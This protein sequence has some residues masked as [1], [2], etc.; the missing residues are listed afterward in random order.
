MPRCCPPCPLE[1]TPSGLTRHRRTCKINRRYL[2][3]GRRVYAE[4]R[5]RQ[6]DL[7]RIQLETDITISL[8][9]SNFY[10]DR[11]YTS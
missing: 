9:F 7:D 10:A 8:S 4:R 5:L 1:S 2:D 6:A 11:S 3:A